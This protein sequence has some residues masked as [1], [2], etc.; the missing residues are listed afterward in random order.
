MEQAERD[1]KNLLHEHFC[2]VN[3]VDV[4]AHALTV[5]RQKNSDYSRGKGSTAAFDSISDE[6]GMSS[7]KVWAVFAQKHWQ[8]IMRF[9][10]DGAV[11]S[12]A[13]EERITDMINY[14]IL[15][16][17]ILKKKNEVIPF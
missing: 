6:L 5:L 7:E 17:V 2:D 15:L 12:E 16:A 9:I 13:I 11:E 14:F 3:M 8:A 10:K 4:V 1:L